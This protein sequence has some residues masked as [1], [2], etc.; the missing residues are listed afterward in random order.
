LQAYGNGTWNI[1]FQ[2]IIPLQVTANN[3]N[4]ISYNFPSEQVSYT[5]SQNS[6]LIV[7]YGTVYPTEQQKVLFIDDF[8]YTNPLL[9]SQW[10]ID[11]YT[12]NSNPGISTSSGYMIMTAQ[13]TSGIETVHVTTPIYDPT[14]Y[15]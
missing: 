8:L 5:T 15:T 7:V 4:S 1:R 12:T 2:G 10:T 6:P 13:T 11:R 9:E 14:Q 3:A